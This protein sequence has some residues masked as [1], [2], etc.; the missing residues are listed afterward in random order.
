[1][2]DGQSVSAVGRYRTTLFVFIVATV[3]VICLLWPPSTPPGEWMRHLTPF[4]DTIVDVVKK[5]SAKLFG[6]IIRNYGIIGNDSTTADLTTVPPEDRQVN[7]TGRYVS[8]CRRNFDNRRIGNQ[9]FNLAAMLHVARLTGR[10]VAMVR[11]HP[12]GWLDRWFDVTVTRVDHINSELCPCVTVGEAAGLAY[13]AKMSKLP[14]RT[15]IVGKSLLVCGWFQSWKY[16]V[17]VESALRR[18]LQ[19]LPNVSATVRDYLDQ[20]RP[21]AWKGQPFSRVGIHVRAGDVMRRDKWGYGYTIPQR[22]YF[23][24]SMS[25]FISQLQDQVHGE[26]I[27]FIV[28]SDSLTWVQTAI[29]FTSIAH[30][31]NRTSPS[32]KNEAIVDVDH[33]EGH[34]AGFDLAL[35]SVCDGVIM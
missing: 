10:R 5:R 33:S 26:R 17:G 30:Q 18:H 28:T 7:K 19:L 1:M 6:V 21:S 31:L 8:M 23:V 24:Q 12:H 16:T 13:N 35:L 15:D 27:Q 3:A 14:N 32:T 9:L 29:N 34:D 20:I 2:L 22:S 4:H 25:R 11:R